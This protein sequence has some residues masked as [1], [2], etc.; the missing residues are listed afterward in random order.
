MHANVMPK[1][2]IADPQGTTIRQAL[3]ALGYDGVIEVRVGK[4]IELTIDALDERE[5]RTQ[6]TE[7][8]ERLLANTVIEDYE[9]T[10]S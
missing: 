6:A 3:P 8:C 5:A 9:V 4:H 7:I 1:R 10:V 2:G